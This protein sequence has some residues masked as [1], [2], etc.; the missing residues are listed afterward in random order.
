MRITLLLFGERVVGFTILTPSIRKINLTAILPEHQGRR[1]AV[2][3]L[4]G[5]IWATVSQEGGTW[6]AW[7]RPETSLRTLRACER[8]G[9]ITLREIGPDPEGDG[10][11]AVEFD[12]L[13]N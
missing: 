9:Q 13:S 10:T 8:R 3:T 11:V 12:V 5:V 2:L 4:F 7:C 1:G 6:H